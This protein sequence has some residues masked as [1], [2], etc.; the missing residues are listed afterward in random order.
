[1]IYYPKQFENLVTDR[2]KYFQQIL[3]RS[4]DSDENEAN[5]I[6]IIKDMLAQMFG[7]DKYE[8]ITSE[9]QI[10]NKYCDIGI[11]INK[12]LIMLIE[13]KSIGTTLKD[14][15]AEQAVNY[16]AHEGNNWVILTNGIQWNIYYITTKKKSGIQ[17]DA[18]CSFNILNDKLDDLLP[19]IYCLSKLGVKKDSLTAFKQHY[20][21]MN[22]YIVTALLMSPSMLYRIKK[23]LRRLFATLNNRNLSSTIREEKI[24]QLMESLIIK[25]MVLESDQFSEA[26]KEIDKYQKIKE[27]NKKRAEEQAQIEEIERGKVI[28]V[29]VLTN[30]KLPS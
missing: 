10:K 24:C 12:E 26:K 14:R 5:T 27:I 8:E 29:E 6:T 2:I 28:N 25:R 19:K 9:Y 4:L 7:Y 1:M 17:D 20:S 3:N 22:E 15:H 16:A 23:E 11:Q 18:L 30:H 13:V 21:I